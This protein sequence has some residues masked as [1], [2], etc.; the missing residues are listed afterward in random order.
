MQKFVIGLAGSIGSGKDAAASFLVGA[1]YTRR[2]FADAM[3]DE[4]KKAFS[5][6]PAAL[7]PLLTREMKEVPS[8]V[9]IYERCQD[10]GFKNVML[11]AGLGDQPQ[12]LRTIMRLW[13]TDYRR[14][15]KPWYW[16]NELDSFYANCAAP[17]VVPDVRFEDEAAW[18]RDHGLLIHIDRE[19]NPYASLM[20]G[21]PSDAGIKRDEL[22]CVINNDSNLTE[23]GV[24]ILSV[25]SQVEQ[26]YA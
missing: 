15:G 17:L 13:G 26:V 20:S 18:V 10:E 5:L 19:D 2:A 1:G 23:L 25:V 4:I 22:D 14:K 7:A 16:V 3:L 11:A 6:H 21:H 8:P 12:S 24:M 9:L